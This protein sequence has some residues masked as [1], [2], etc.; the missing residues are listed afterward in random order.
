M[1]AA[2][3]AFE[4]RLQEFS[5]SF[6]ERTGREA[7]E[8]QSLLTADK[9]DRDRIRSI[10]HRIAGG[11]GIFGFTSLTDPAVSLEGAIDSEDPEGEIFDKTTKLV[12]AIRH[13]IESGDR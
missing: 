11:A 9:P 6:L 1:S 12:D 7:D 10:A 2:D 8:L 5:Q 3:A 4:Q 13:C